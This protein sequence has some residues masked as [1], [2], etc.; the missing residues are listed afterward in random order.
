VYF[1]PYKTSLCK[2][3]TTFTSSPADPVL[4]N[5]LL[6]ALAKQGIAYMREAQQ[7]QSPVLLEKS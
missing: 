4:A 1:G 7:L 6:N 5:P 3:S 2:Y